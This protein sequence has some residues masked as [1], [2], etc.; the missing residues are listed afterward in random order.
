MGWAS[1]DELDADGDALE[2]LIDRTP[3]VDPWCSGLDWVLSSH[4]AFADRAIA[5]TDLLLWSDSTVGAALFHRSMT[6]D[7][8]VLVAGLEPM[9]GFASPLLG[10]DLVAC[11]DMAAHHLASLDRW[12]LCV[13]NGLPLS[14]DLASAVAAPLARLGDVQAYHGIVRQVADISGGADAWFA[15]RS[16][17][18][19]KELRRAERRALAEG[20]EFVEVAD[21]PDAYDRCLAIERASWKGMTDDGIT[22][23]DMGRFY[24]DLTDRLQ[25]Q[26]RL[27]ATIARRGAD[28]I[29]FVLGG[30]RHERYRGLQ[31]SYAEDAREFS[32]SHLLQLHTLR[33]LAADR[34]TL[35]D[36][37]MDM[38]YKQ[39][40]ATRAEPS[41]SIVVRRATAERRRRF[42]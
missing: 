31:L 7:G 18:F 1:L 26:G 35:Y 25:R 2:A 20:V 33:T 41:M 27:R 16:S 29:G 39:R 23:P 5:P 21:D 40:W 6:I 32:I 34:I 15:S 24:R 11:A 19:R 17:K 28:D 10:P 22:K 3:H 30:V 12:D 9:W 37:G 4:R 8:A 42:G 38:D 13:I 14:V 36:M